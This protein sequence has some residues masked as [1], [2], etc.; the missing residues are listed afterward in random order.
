M[1]K[2]NK[3][4]SEWVWEKRIIERRCEKLKAEGRSKCIVIRDGRGVE[5]DMETWSGSESATGKHSGAGEKSY[6]GEIWNF[7]RQG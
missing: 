5:I 2:E 7:R 4:E 6:L 3:K 1:R